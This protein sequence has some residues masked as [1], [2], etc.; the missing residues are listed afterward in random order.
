MILGFQVMNFLGILVLGN[1]IP[2][3]R[4]RSLNTA[5]LVIQAVSFERVKAMDVSR[6]PVRVHEQYAY[7]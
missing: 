1:S 5:T 6:F 4:L 3:L 2:A 7:I